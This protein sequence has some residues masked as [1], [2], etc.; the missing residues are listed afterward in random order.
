[1]LFLKTRKNSIEFLTPFFYIAPFLSLLIIF[2][3]YVFFSGALSSFTD[4]EGINPGSFIGFE[5][6]QEAL[7]NFDFWKSLST[8]IIYTVL[9]IALQIPFAFV[10]AYILNMVPKIFKGYLRASFFV[11]VLINGVVIALMFRMLF[12]KD[13]G[14][15][16]W[17]LGLLRLPNKIDWVN[18]S[19]YTIILMV[20]VSFW[21]WT[22]FH[23]VY[24]LA[25][26][27]TIDNSLYE[28]AKVEGASQ[29]RV[30]FQITMPMMKPALTFCF[31]TSAIGCLKLF[32]LPFM[33]FPNAGYGPGYSARTTVAYIYEQ[34]FSQQFRFGYASAVGWLLFFIIL[35]V[36]IFQ[37]KV[38]K[39]GESDEN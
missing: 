39:A 27:Q 14:L 31:I 13:V 8:T 37:L 23:M 36:S 30:L 3:I 10:L 19:N 16:N 1:M 15:I 4:A 12:N 5:N 32:D 20:F 18:D 17:F 21:Q 29:L 24:L 25:S 22:G 35:I 6:Y 33:L 11:P 34:A 9:S 38:L 7:T 2:N 26:L 28:A